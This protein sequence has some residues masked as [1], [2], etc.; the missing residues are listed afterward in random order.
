MSQKQKDETMELTGKVLDLCA[1]SSTHA[2]ILEALLLAFVTVAKSHPCCTQSAADAA[3]R[4][5]IR[6]AA[7]AAERPVGTQIH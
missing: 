5:S 3:M 1:Q 7:A 4:Q 6:L 2:V